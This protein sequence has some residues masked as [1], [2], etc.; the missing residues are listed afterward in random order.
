MNIKDVLKISEAVA[1]DVFFKD[2]VVRKKDACIICKTEY[3][4]KRVE[5]Q[6]YN[7]YDLVRDDLALEMKPVYGV[8]FNV[9]HKWFEKYQLRPLNY[10]RDEE[11]VAFSGNQFGER[12]DYYFL[13]NRNEHDKD[14]RVLRT[15]VVKNAKFIFNK[16]SSLQDYYRYIVEETINGKRKYRDIGI[17][18]AMEF[19]TATKIAAPSD[20]QRVK[21]AVL[22]KIEIMKDRNEP[23]I[24]MYYDDLPM[25]L[26]DLESTDFLSGKWGAIPPK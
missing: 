15:E 2:F 17:E 24:M 9:L 16:Y 11:S 10:V 1:S 13:E 22:Q 25:I 21:E 19:L 8:R 26:E 23:N 6:H 5:F 12:E 18:W 4:Y 20:Y 14:L 3:G 7:T